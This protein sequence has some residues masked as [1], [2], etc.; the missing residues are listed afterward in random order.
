MSPTPFR[1]ILRIAFVWVLFSI[2]PLQAQMV[3]DV[4]Q[5]SSP[6]RELLDLSHYGEGTDIGSVLSVWGI[7]VTGPGSRTVHRILHEHLSPPLNVLPA[8]AYA[9]V[10]SN[11][12]A[13]ESED[14]S[15][16]PLVFH[17]GQGSSTSS[18]RTENPS[19][20]TS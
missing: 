19:P 1:S 6:R 4:D 18:T 16:R 15:H 3:V 11:E 7:R 5:H 10:F 2:G 8:P 9:D 14:S 17:S 20:S 12:P 13:D